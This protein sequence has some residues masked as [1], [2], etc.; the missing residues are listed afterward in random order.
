MVGSGRPWRRSCS[1]QTPETRALPEARTMC[2]HRCSSWGREEEEGPSDGTAG[3]ETH[4]H[5]NR[6]RLVWEERTLGM[7]QSSAVW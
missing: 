7:G 1:D 5:P 4:K 6:S 3:V 2:Q